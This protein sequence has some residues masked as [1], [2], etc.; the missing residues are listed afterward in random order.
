[1]SKTDEI[2]EKISL[3]KFW[4]G[5]LIAIAISLGTWIIPNISNYTNFRFI[6]ANVFFIFIIFLIIKF[7]KRIEKYINELREL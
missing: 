4:M 6:V 1:M 7:H 3:L 2:K 5:V